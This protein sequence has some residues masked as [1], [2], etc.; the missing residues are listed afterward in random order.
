MKIRDVAAVVETIAPLRLA[1]DWDNVGLLIGDPLTDV[2][3][4]LLTIDVTG[5]VLS[6]AIKQKA[7]LIIAYHP[8]IWD[9]LKKI[10]SE[11]AVKPR[12]APAPAAW[13]AL[14]TGAEAKAPRSTRGL[15]YEVIRRG[16]AVYSIHTAL[17]AAIGGVN[18]G[19]AEMI[20]IKNPQPIGD[21]VSHPAGDNY[22]LVVFVPVASLHLVAEAVFA[23]G[24][25]AIGNYSNCG[26]YSEGTGT[27]RPLAGAKPAIGKRG[28]TEK[29]QEVRFE[30]IVPAEKLAAVVDA[31]KKAHPYETPAYDVIRLSNSHEKFGLG[32]IGELERALPMKTIMQRIKKATGAKAIGIVG[33]ENRLVKN[34]AVCAGSC[35]VIINLVIEAK[36]DL[37]LTGELKHHQ[38]LA[39]QEAGLTC[40]CLTHTVS[41]R[42]ML[43][44]L[45]GQLR[46]QLKGVSIIVSKKD[47][48]PFEWKRI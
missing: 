16:I 3:N 4:I 37:Y 25:G 45:A 29:V 40:L 12:L 9:A 26:F 46:K 42:F 28:R 1:Q 27:F 21:F 35:G 32:R 7:K 33:K 2:K 30:A 47:A 10:T 38:A 48:D 34:A 6:E 23:A 13:A 44:K 41:E 8:I 43:K 31:M 36:A 11:P 14:A 24:A 5:E 22:K 17:D 15:V 20:G 39:A 19:L 18:D